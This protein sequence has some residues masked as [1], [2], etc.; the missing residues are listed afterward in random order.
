[1]KEVL[2]LKHIPNLLS[3]FRIIL[4]PFFIWQIGQ[5]NMIN[6]GIILLLSGLTD[7]L[8]GKLARRFGWI[9]DLGKVLDPVADKL[10]QASISLSFIFLLKEYRIFFAIILIKDFIMLILGGFLMKRGATI[11]GAKWFGK[12]STFVFYIFM[13]LLILIPSIPKWLGRT[14]MTI[15]TT[16][17]V[18]SGLLYIPDFIDYY[19]GLNNSKV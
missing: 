13:I 4:I 5:G 3:V 2:N 15:S 8:D 12:V 7:F 1:M 14:M 10:T 17:A 6:A 9:T 16:L 19:K 11:K 18:A